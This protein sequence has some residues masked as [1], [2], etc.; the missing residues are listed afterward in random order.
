MALTKPP[1][2]AIKVLVIDD[3]NIARTQ[4]CELLSNAG[5]AVG[6]LASPIGATKSITEQHINVVV[7]DV[8]MPSI[9]GDRLAA[10]FRGNPR[11]QRLGVI[12][13]TGSTES[14]LSELAATAQADAVLSKGRLSELVALVEKVYQRRHLGVHG[15]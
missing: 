6:G 7:L 2:A 9:R 15:I 3:D 11:L 12:L 1:I 4:M 13:V 10:L 14:E 5:H 8:Q